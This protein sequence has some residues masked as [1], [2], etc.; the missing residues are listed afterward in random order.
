MKNARKH[1]GRLRRGVNSRQA[2]DACRN[3]FIV[4]IL[5]IMGKDKTSMVCDKDEVR[6]AVNCGLIILTHDLS[7]KLN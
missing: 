1:R 3:Q 2:E 6:L 5:K 4:K 7:P